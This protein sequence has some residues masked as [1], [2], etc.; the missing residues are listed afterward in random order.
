MRVPLEWLKEFVKVRSKPEDLA[1]RLTMS[2]LEVESIERLGKDAI[3][4]V[5]VTPN[6]AD[7]LSIVGMAREV[8]AVTGLKF[9]APSFKA[10]GGKGKISSR[11]RVSVKSPSLCPRYCARVIEG[12][13]VGPSPAWLAG[14]L[15]A[16]GVRSVNNV[17][18]ATNYVMLETGQPLHAFDLSSIRGGRIVVRAAGEAARFTTL[19]GIDRM[20]EAEDLLICD[21]EGPV[22]L[23][24]VM[25]G[26]NSEVRDSTT[27]LLL[28]SACFAPRGIRRTSR[29]LGL[30]SESSRRFERGVD[31]AGTLQAL[32]K[33]AALIVKTAGGVP[34][35]DWIDAYP[36]RIGPRSLVLSESEVKRILGV[37][38]KAPQVVGIL[39]A[40]GFSAARAAGGRIRIKVPTFRPDIER[41]IDVIEE[42]ARLYG[43]DRIPETMP[44]V[45]VA[46]LSRPRFHREV[47]L[48][49]ERLADAGLSEALLY[50]FTSEEKTAP[51]AELC[52]QPVKITNPLSSEHGVMCTTLLPGLLDAMKL[53]ASRQRP[54]ARLFALQKVFYRPMA[55]GPSDEPRRVAGVLSGE[56]FPGAWERAKEQLDFYDAKGVVESALSCMGLSGQAIF[57]RGEA[58]RFLHP[59]SFAYVIV[60]GKR[61]GFVGQLHPEV[62]ARWELKEKVFAFELSFEAMAE[63]AAA[64]SPRFTELSRFP[65]VERDLALVV[66]ERVPAVEIERTIEGCAVDLIEGV[67]IFDVY[68]GTGL[69]AGHKSLGVSLR[70]S[71][72]D[73][74][75]TDDEVEAAQVK[76]LAALKMKLGAE[77]RT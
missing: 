72:G 16:C 56:R 58:Y 15:A 12:V 27:S 52:S 30:S 49:R 41:P 7:C 71:G 6:R 70:F 55:M 31:P 43:Y 4:D 63:V 2:G 23:A 61:V 1:S 65:F 10:P 25:G 57:Q 3:L 75:L 42:V 33:L 8:A 50:G 32:Q 18:D 19:D 60:G 39:S 11:A 68:R 24:G 5:A 22:A 44:L 13:K 36:K 35:A 74:T 47:E 20:L 29:R 53:N 67:R 45:R 14:R 76:I 40:L 77:Q 17:V 37:T 69:P 28:E 21:G 46:P 48:L 38:V 59:G 34:T 54:G 64:H 66:E 26:Q 73:R 9:E 62:A 51:F